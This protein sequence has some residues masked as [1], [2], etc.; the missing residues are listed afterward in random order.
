MLKY[1]KDAG[2]LPAT[3]C[4]VRCARGS[5]LIVV[6]AACAVRCSFVVMTFLFPTATY[7]IFME[8]Y[9]KRV[10]A[11][12]SCVPH[13][14]MRSLQKTQG[15]RDSLYS[16]GLLA[17]SHSGVDA[18]AGHAAP[19]GLPLR[20]VISDQITTTTTTASTTPPLVC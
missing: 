12:P 5:V 11:H 18:S 1:I 13:M 14:I 2:F 8:K 17:S 7:V 19:R 20:S 15:A 4:A 10:R 3:K 9:T 16:T 6:H